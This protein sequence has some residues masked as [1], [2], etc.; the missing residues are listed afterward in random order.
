MPQE[1]KY[2]SISAENIINE[3]NILDPSEIKVELIAQWY[4]ATVTYAP[5][6]SAA[7]RLVRHGNSAI[8]TIPEYQPYEGRKRFSIGHEIGHFILHESFI[9]YKLC[10]AKDMIDWHGAKKLEA[11]ANKFSAE[12]LMPYFLFFPKTVKKT[13]NFKLIKALSL[14]FRTSLTSTA[15][16]YIHVTKEPCALIFSV[17]GRIEWYLK[18]T[19]DFR[20]II[21]GKG[22]QVDADSIAY[23]AFKG[24][25]DYEEGELVPASAW[26]EV[27]YPSQENLELHESTCYMPTFNSTLTL[28]WEN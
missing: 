9:D 16:R 15:V 24:K 22:A 6:K 20:Y 8:I 26:I 21:K 10:S 13:P 11:E 19:K 1:T 23:E 5:M 3:L 28:L 18:N 25:G 14:E 2:S 7:G 27:K 17:D 12:L 4:G